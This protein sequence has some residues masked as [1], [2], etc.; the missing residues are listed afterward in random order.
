MR[1]RNPSN[2]LKSRRKKVPTKAGRLRGLL[3][4]PNAKNALAD[5]AIGGVLFGPKGAFLGAAVGGLG[6]KGFFHGGRSKSSRR[7][8]RSLRSSKR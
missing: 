5:A 8:L 6:N 2:T 3:D 1:K 7:T 4:S